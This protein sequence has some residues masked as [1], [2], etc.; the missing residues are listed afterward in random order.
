MLIL[1]ASGVRAQSGGKGE[2]AKPTGLVSTFL[3]IPKGSSAVSLLIAGRADEAKVSVNDE[4]QMSGL[5]HDCNMMLKFTPLTAGKRCSVCPCAVSNAE[6]V[7][8]VPLKLASWESMLQGLPRGTALRIAFNS[9][10]D[11]TSGLKSLQVDLRAVLV[12]V[13]GAAKLDH[14]AILE[15]ARPLGATSADIDVPSG[16]VRFGLKSD[17]TP[18]KAKKLEKALEEM[19]AVLNWDKPV[20]A[21]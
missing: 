1:V 19:G 2:Q 12:P 4:T 20:P 10:D 11:A 16:Q 14:D 9:G 7:A 8:G 3:S 6:C 15:A 17:W 18:D 13:A 5:C 21:K